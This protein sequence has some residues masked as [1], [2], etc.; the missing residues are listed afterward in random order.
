M[1]TQNHCVSENLDTLITRQQ[2]VAAKLARSGKKLK[3][4]A[5]RSKLMILLNQRDLSQ[6][7]LI[8]NQTVNG[9]RAA[10]LAT[11]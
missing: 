4:R 3:A 8:P 5:A 1:R 6:S 2:E 7:F 10:D 9:R 11:D